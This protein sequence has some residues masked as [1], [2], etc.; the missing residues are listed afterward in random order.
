M[1][2]RS[3]PLRAIE[4]AISPARATICVLFAAIAALAG[5]QLINYRAV[6]IGARQYAHVAGVAAP[7]EVAAATPRSAHGA[8]V[9][10]IAGAALV[11]LVAAI[12][13]RRRALARLLVPL[14][15]AVIVIALAVDRPHGLEVGSPGLAYEGTRAV[16]L[17]GF[18]AEIAAA[19]TLALAGFMLPLQP[20]P[21][22]RARRRRVDDSSRPA[23]SGRA[24]LE[25]REARG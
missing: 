22:A 8:W 14:G 17:S 7:P 24:Q 11:I 19:A 1:R 16:L 4:R 21:E 15:A 12:V 5:S 23:A 9:L 2:A 13:L 20:P 3:R 10:A 25:P 6:E 18:S